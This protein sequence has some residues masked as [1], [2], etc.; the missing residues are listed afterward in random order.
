MQKEFS[1]WIQTWCD[2][3]TLD[4]FPRVLLVGDSITRGYE[5]FVREKLK[6]VAYVD[7]LSTSYAVDAPIYG[8]LLTSFV[9]DSRYD[10]IH[11]NHGLHGVHMSQSCYEQGMA[12]IIAELIVKHKVV[13]ATTTF[14]F[15]PGNERPSAEWAQKVE[16]RNQVLWRLAENFSCPVNDLYQSSLAIDKEKRLYDGTHYT[17]EGSRVLAETVATCIKEKL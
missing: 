9:Q 16:E 4:D 1:E 7:Y 17:D 10:L 13:L 12:K 3:T 2:S 8:Q 15:E 14:V 11:F 5:R 6:G